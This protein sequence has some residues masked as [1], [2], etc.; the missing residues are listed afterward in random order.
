MIIPNEAR[1]VVGG[2]WNH[3]PFDRTILILV[4]L[5]V[6]LRAEGAVQ[7]DAGRGPELGVDFRQVR[8][9]GAVG[10]VEPLA[11]LAV[12][13]AVRR[14]LRDLQLLGGQEVAAYRL[15]LAAA[16]ARGAQLVPG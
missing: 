14:Q 6:R 13:Q 12:G 10:D 4:F 3:G 15:P 16:L 1:D 5:V 11:D 9:D 7:L 8:A 2:R